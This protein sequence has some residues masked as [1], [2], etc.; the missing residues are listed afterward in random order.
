M[1]Q[2]IGCKCFGAQCLSKCYEVLLVFVGW[3][4]GPEFLVGYFMK[5]EV[6]KQLEKNVATYGVGRVLSRLC[7][8]LLLSVFYITGL[9]FVKCVSLPTDLV[10]PP[11]FSSGKPIWTFSVLIFSSK[12]WSLSIW[13]SEG[14]RTA[15]SPP[16]ALAALCSRAHARA[17]QRMCLLTVLE[18]IGCAEACLRRNSG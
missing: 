2:L 5:Y 3:C 15:Q 18:V 6:Q 10:S 8:S 17:Q 1:N 14:V 16:S 7:F 12:L 11:I 4:A 13:H 9:L